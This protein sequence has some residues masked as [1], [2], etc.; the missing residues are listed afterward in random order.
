MRDLFSLV[1]KQDVDRI[2]KVYFPTCTKVDAFY[3][4]VAGLLKF[5]NPKIEI[6]FYDDDDELDYIKK[7]EIYISEDEYPELLSCVAHTALLL[8]LPSE[9][10]PACSCSKDYFKE[11]RLT[12]PMENKQYMM[13]YFMEKVDE[14]AEDLCKWVERRI[15]DMVY[16]Q[17]FPVYAQA[18]LWHHW[19]TIDWEKLAKNHIISKIT[20][21]TLC[22]VIKREKTDKDEEIIS[23]FLK[24]ICRYGIIDKEIDNKITDLIYDTFS[25][26]NTLEYFL[27]GFQ[28]KMNDKM[29]IRCRENCFG[30]T[31]DLNKYELRR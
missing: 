23:N 8:Y 11:K 29:V 18:Y 17:P 16:C 4:E 27:N 25:D 24:A 26:N 1:E 30:C 14:K 6:C 12:E 21:I 2:T 3:V 20:M 22:E 19:R 15:D 31:Y 7:D 10:L 9:Y 28:S 5:A 13:K